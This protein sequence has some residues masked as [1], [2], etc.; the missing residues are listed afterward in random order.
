MNRS[1][2]VPECSLLSGERASPDGGRKPCGGREPFPWPCLPPCTV[3]LRVQHMD[4][5]VCLQAGA[6]SV[7]HPR[8][9]R[10]GPGPQGYPV[11]AALS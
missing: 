1:C 2:F 6:W 11:R 3:A 10:Q 7:L 5:C 8:G 9:L 4:M